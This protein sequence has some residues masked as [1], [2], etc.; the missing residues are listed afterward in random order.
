MKTTLVLMFAF[1]TAASAQAFVSV[2]G[3][4]IPAACGPQTTL[5]EDAAPVLQEVCLGGFDGEEFDPSSPVVA[6]RYADGTL[7]SF[8]V[9]GSANLFIAI[10]GGKTRANLFLVGPNGEQTTMRVIKNANGQI[11]AASGQLSQTDYTVPGFAPV[12][13]LH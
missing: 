13:T 6:F 11:E 5:S 3:E 10:R 1:L 12:F 2:P 4:F 8:K 9:V 7:K